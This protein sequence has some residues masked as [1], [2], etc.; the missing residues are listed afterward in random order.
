[1]DPDLQNIDR[2]CRS[3]SA[4]GAS[5]LFLEEGAPPQV[6]LHGGLRVLEEAPVLPESMTA[7][8]RQCRANDAAQDADATFTNSAGVRF[9]VN[10]YRKL[11][12]RSA[13]LRAISSDIP[14]LNSLG[15]PAEILMEWMTRD[16]GL[17]LVC[18]PTGSGKSTTLASCLEWLNQQQPRH[19]VTIEDPIE[20]LFHSKQCLF[21]QREVGLDTESFYKGL[22]QA[23]RQSPDVIM[24]GEVRDAE[25]ASTALQAA[26]VGHLVIATLHSSSCAES[27][28]RI[29]RLFGPTDRDGISMVLATQVV[30]VICQRLLPDTQGGLVVAVE[31]FQNQALSRKYILENRWKDLTDLIGR[32]DNPVNCSLVRWLVRLCQS[33]RLTEEAAASVLANPQDLQR[34]LRGMSGG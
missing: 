27:I 15:L 2:L 19:V 3:M 31:H 13:V 20:Y 10:L 32:A 24:L 9:R 17:I 23:L 12:W 11:G 33:G 4:H 5:D 22:R 8:W 6:R 26:E 16:A 14:D 1:M 34:A 21:S 28:E 25:T 18:G 29:A 30:G 7:L